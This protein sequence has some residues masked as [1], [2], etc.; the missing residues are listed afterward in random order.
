MKLI[1]LLSIIIFIKV[2]L[3]KVFAILVIILSFILKK[4]SL[5][6]N[7]WNKYFLTL[8]EAFLIKYSFVVYLI[9]TI[10][11]SLVAYALFRAFKF[12]YPL[13]LSCTL[14]IVCMFITWFKYRRKGKKEIIEA[15]YKVKKSATE[16]NEEQDNIQQIE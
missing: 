15:L 9:S 5:Y 4:K 2:I 8:S 1:M 14:L 12:Q 16:E 3:T 6:K 7:D 10:S 13:S 11:S